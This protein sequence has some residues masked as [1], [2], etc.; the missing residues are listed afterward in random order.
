MNKKMLAAGSFICAFLL[1]VS[2]LFG[3]YSFH[4]NLWPIK[5]LKS[6]KGH[7]DRSYDR[8]VG[9]KFDS[10]K[11]NPRL[12]GFPG[13]KEIPCPEQTGNTMVLLL[14]GQSMTSNDASQRYTSAYGD[15]VTNYFAGKCFISSSPLLGTSGQMGES[16]TLLG[17]KLIASGLAD[18]VVLIPAAIGGS[19]ITLWKKGGDLNKLLLSVLD[20]VKP[21][22]RITH[23]L[24]HQGETDFQLRTS[25]SAYIDMFYSLVESIRSESVNA[26]IY[27]SV[28][29]KCG[30]DPAWSPDN[31]I[32]IAQRTLAN[33]D[34]SRMIFRGI[35]TDSLMDSV[36]RVGECHFSGTGQEKFANAWLGV[37]RAAQ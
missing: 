22:Y 32:A 34:R 18:R 27:P 14:I 17:N 11:P 30:K 35:D 23:I 31:P 26:P 19:G 8:A 28:A 36:D 16:W 1:C 12:I 33:E 20:D 10:T 3:A 29:T 24:W 4:R 25:E 9:I 37:L 21:H 13:K 2:Y 5:E 15:R 7:M 6:I